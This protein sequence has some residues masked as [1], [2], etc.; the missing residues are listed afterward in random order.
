[1]KWKQFVTAL[2]TRLGL[3]RPG[4]VYYIGGAEVLPPPLAPSEE[5][6]A[7]ARLMA[8]DPAARAALYVSIVIRLRI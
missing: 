8:G 4:R 2:L 5:A 6:E 1:M 7:L 3:L